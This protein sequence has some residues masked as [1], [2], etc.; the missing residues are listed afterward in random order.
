MTTLEIV[1]ILVRIAWLVG[2]RRVRHRPVADELAGHGPQRQPR[3]GRRHDHR[4]RRD[5]RP[6]PRPSS[7]TGDGISAIVWV[8][9]IVGIVARRRP[10]AVHRADRED[11][12]DAAA[13]VA[14][15][16][17]R[18]RRGGAH[19]DRRLPAPRRRATPIRI[20]TN[21]FIVLDI[22]IGSITFTGSIIASGKL[23]GLI[24]GQ[25]DPRSRA[26]GS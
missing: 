18:R 21:I 13:G 8:I 11:D 16:R 7:S 24:P 23:Q 6:D 15:Q 20:D 1:E 22:I 10:R 25:A 19:R 14:V 9:I 3:V 5:G 12:R 26:A 4:H 17:G 2:R